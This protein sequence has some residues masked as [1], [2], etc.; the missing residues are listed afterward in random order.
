M[1]FE[2]TLCGLNGRKICDVFESVI[3]LQQV[4][5]KTIDLNSCIDEI[6]I[7]LRTLKENILTT[8]EL[9]SLPKLVKYYIANRNSAAFRKKKNHQARNERNEGRNDNL[10]AYKEHNSGPLL[11][12]LIKSIYD[13][14]NKFDYVSE[15][16]KIDFFNKIKSV[17]QTASTASVY[18]S[19]LLNNI[20]HRN[21]LFMSSERMRYNTHPALAKLES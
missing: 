7:R 2:K 6:E 15:K 12:A 17:L 18:Y 20:V 21:S 11:F 5:N 3:K 19:Q 13:E 9:R 8:E 10:D 4:K 16:L 14:V 1:D